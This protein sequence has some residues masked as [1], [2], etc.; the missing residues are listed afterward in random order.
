M[1]FELRE[2]GEPHKE[3]D[4]SIDGQVAVLSSFRSEFRRRKS[5]RRDIFEAHAM[6]FATTRFRR[7]EPYKGGL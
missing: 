3:V 6:T 4:R 5:E 2:S 1:V 7:K